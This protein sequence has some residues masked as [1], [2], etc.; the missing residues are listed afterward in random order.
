MTGLKSAVLMP[1]HPKCWDYRCLLP[2]PSYSSGGDF[3]SSFCL[4]SNVLKGRRLYWE[5]DNILRKMLLPPAKALL[6]V[7][8]LVVSRNYLCTSK[9][10][11]LKKSEF[12]LIKTL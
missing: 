8:Y 7:Y 10:F 11:I 2:C 9:A 3:S 1:L 5:L 12:M 4:E 6:V